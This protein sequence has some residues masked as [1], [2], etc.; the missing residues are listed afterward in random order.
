M[1]FKK[2]MYPLLALLAASQVWGDEMYINDRDVEL[3]NFSSKWW[4]T[5]NPSRY[6]Q[7]STT[8]LYEGQTLEFMFDGSSEVNVIAELHPNHGRGEVFV[9]DVSVGQI[10]LFGDTRTS[11]QQVFTLS[12]YPAGVHTAKI[13]TLD[14]KYFP[15]EAIKIKSEANTFVNNT[16]SNIDYSDYWRISSGRSAGLVERDLHFTGDKGSFVEIPFVGTGIEVK[17]E[18]FSTHGEFL[19]ELD[20]ISLGL[21]SLDNPD[22][23]QS[24]IFYKNDLSYGDHSLKLTFV[25]GEF[26]VLDAYAPKFGGEH[27]LSSDSSKDGVPDKM[28]VDLDNDGVG[29]D[30]DL[31]PSDPTKKDTIESVIKDANGNPSDI[32]VDVSLVEKH[33]EDLISVR[34]AEN[35]KFLKEIYGDNEIVYHP[36]QISTHLEVDDLQENHPLL[37][38]VKGKYLGLANE[39]NGVRNAGFSTNVFNN[40]S[41]GTHLEYEPHFKSVFHWLLKG[42]GAE[43]P[44]LEKNVRFVF[45]S[46]TITNYGTEWLS[47]N[48]P[49]WDV[50]ICNDINTINECIGDSPD[51]I[52][53][54]GDPSPTLEEIDLVMT[55]Y[56]DVNKLYVHSGNWGVFNNANV[57]AS[58]LG[59]E[60]TKYQHGN[61]YLLDGADWDNV[62]EM[63]DGDV[64]TQFGYFVRDIREDSLPYSVALC[65]AEGW[66]E[67]CNN[68]NS[69]Q[70]G[71]QKPFRQT[72]MPIIT[73]FD[74]K[75]IDIFEED[76]KDLLKLAILLGDLYRRDIQLPMDNVESSNLDFMKAKFAD[77]VVKSVRLYNPAQPDMGNFSRS[78]FDHVVPT[79]RTVNITSKRPFRASGAYA[80][81]GKTF[82]V[83]RNDTNENKVGIFINAYR[84]ESTREFSRKYG[85]NRPDIVQSNIMYIKAGES[86]N[87]TNPFG[88]PIQVWFNDTGVENKL[89]FENVGEHPFWSPSVDSEEFMN[90]VEQGDYDIVE[91]TTEYFELHS[92][93]DRFKRTMTD[94]RF[95]TP[96][97]LYAGI[98]LY[99]HNYING[100][101]GFKG[102]G[103]DVH[104][105]VQAFVD[106]NGFKMR[107]FDIVKHANSDQ[108]SCGSG[109]SGNP[110]DMDW[111]FNPLGHGDLHEM[112]HSLEEHLF[113]FDGA[114]RHGATNFY[115]YYSKR[116]Y[117]DNTGFK[118]TCQNLNYDGMLSRITDSLKQD[119]PFEYM[120]DFG[121]A[122]WS[123]SAM[124][125]IQNLAFAE[126]M[127]GFEDGWQL[128][129]MLHVMAEHYKNARVSNDAWLSKRD[130]LGFSTFEHSDK[131]SQNDFMYVALAKILNYD[132][133]DFYQMFGRTLSDKSLSQ[134]GLEH[135]PLAPRAL[136]I[137]DS[138]DALCWELLG[139][140]VNVD[141]V[142]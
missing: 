76:G 53:T 26:G 96:E 31:Y 95:D 61:W 140:S 72:I 126:D 60:S 101:A 62:E 67:E 84:P 13:I 83:T 12:G 17:S 21:L 66:H 78:N 40:L 59:F 116:K 14:N 71:F 46:S 51:L 15:I 11:Q 56:S 97:K 54:S 90:K 44:Q 130:S 86:I 64:V 48:Y 133:R 122:N 82:R 119:D 23:I 37:V 118:D 27:Y 137:P 120:R 135:Y 20:G 100:L 81:P 43:L 5:T 139:S 68:L 141:E 8:T 79:T 24:T 104:P 41:K 136:Y 75:G 49:E 70:N 114:T 121:Q 58:Y 28:D 38:G 107:T 124:V 77:T 111:D 89:T 1:I 142:E 16:D 105:D 94:P 98:N 108:A 39:K 6:L 125:V 35:L 34:V 7:T 65:R 2:P 29:D 52:I 9:D 45:A 57:V 92:R 63:I 32:T 3:L 102:D 91:F 69:F 123:E 10:D 50:A 18:L 87:I 138:Q 36:D 22:R 85:Y 80:I 131:I 128:L 30:V 93:L 25:D 55:T 134:V 74:E 47:T 103:I 109:C 113:T 129:P 117:F 127:A 110:Y 42:D 19:V 73:R 112:G 99:D 4:Q 132:F 106:E 33:I 88:G 115:S